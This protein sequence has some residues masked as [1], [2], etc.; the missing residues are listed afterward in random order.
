MNGEPYTPEE[1]TDWSPIFA[2]AGWVS[3]HARLD[4]ARIAAAAEVAAELRARLPALLLHVVDQAAPILAKHKQRA[5]ARSPG[6]GNPRLRHERAAA[7]AWLTANLPPSGER[8]RGWR[9]HWAGALADARPWGTDGV[10]SYDTAY[11]WVGIAT[12]TQGLPG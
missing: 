11:E 12:K 2:P 6:A 5:N 1:L 3:E 4:A 7:M 8:V 9:K 10:V